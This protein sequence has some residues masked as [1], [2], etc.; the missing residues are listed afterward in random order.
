MIRF[1]LSCDHDHGFES[2]FQSSDAFDTLARAGR[3]SC[4]VCGSGAVTKALMA[5]NVRVGSA[6]PA[7]ETTRPLDGKGSELEIALAELRRQ[8]EENSDYVGLNFAREVRAMQEGDAPERA[9][10]GEARPDEARRLLEDGLPVMPLPFMP[11][12]KVN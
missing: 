4:P 6:A 12:R 2:W 5:P 8:V 9:I 11:R 7:P 3:L 1:S 10:Y